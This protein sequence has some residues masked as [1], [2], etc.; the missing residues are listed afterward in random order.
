MKFTTPIMLL[1]SLFTYA[2][3]EAADAGTDISR[4]HPRDFSPEVLSSNHLAARG[5]PKVPKGGDDKYMHVWVRT[6]KRPKTYVDSTYKSYDGL[7]K[8]MKDTGGQHKDVVVG[9]SKGYYEYGMGFE[10]DSWK[11]NK[12]GADGA[13]VKEYSGK[14]EE[15]KDGQEKYE[16][17]GQ[18]KSGKES[19]KTIEKMG[20]SNLLL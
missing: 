5:A 17:K 12:D 11:K 14:W 4:D 6:D 1:A 9:N 13:K 2:S 18:C 15:V 8:L 7:D 20:E 19:H 16:Y 10:G 3:A